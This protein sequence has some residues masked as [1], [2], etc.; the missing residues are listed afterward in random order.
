MN[1]AKYNEALKLLKEAVEGGEWEPQENVSY[2]EISGDGLIAKSFW[3]EDNNGYLYR[4][5]LGIFPD[6]P[7]GKKAAEERVELVRE[8]VKSL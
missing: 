8:Y 4:D 5:F 2:L 1:K 6:T 7:E 3:H